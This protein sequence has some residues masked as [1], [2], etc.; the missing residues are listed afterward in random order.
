MLEIHQLK[1]QS[2]NQ[3]HQ[4]VPLINQSNTLK[5]KKRIINQFIKT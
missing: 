5:R 3:N 4:I 1:D 2:L